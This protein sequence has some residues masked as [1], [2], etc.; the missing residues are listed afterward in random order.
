MA[1]EPRYLLDTNICIFILDA[2]HPRLRER[3]EQVEEGALATSTIVLAELLRGT[4]LGREREMRRLQSLLAVVPALPF[5]E[6]AAKAYARLPFRRGRFDRLIA[7]H[8]L[9]RGLTVV[10]ANV[11]DFSDVR[12]LQVEDWTTP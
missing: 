6:V 7:A 2:T 12:G 3:L 4:G 5:D 10:T 11:R 8:A 9:S 1:V